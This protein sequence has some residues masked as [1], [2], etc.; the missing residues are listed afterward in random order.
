MARAARTGEEV[1][2]D[3]GPDGYLKGISSPQR[4]A[5]AKEFGIK[6]IH[7]VPVA[8]GVVEY[9]RAAGEEVEITRLL[10]ALMYQILHPQGV[11]D[12]VKKLGE[13]GQLLVMLVKLEEA[14]ALT[15]LSKAVVALY[16]AVMSYERSLERDVLAAFT[17][18]RSVEGSQS[19]KK[20]AAA[21][22]RA[23]FLVNLITPVFAVARGIILCSRF[24]R[25][26]WSM[27]NDAVIYADKGVEQLVET[28]RQVRPTNPC[29]CVCV[30]VCACV[31]VRVC[32]SRHR[33]AWDET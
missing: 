26:L 33:W 5:L 22:G 24:L 10:N 4:R 2:L 25:A 30:C 21:R 17:Y 3:C 16:D 23:R 28:G 8:G 19:L 13:V 31:C 9:G 20:D 15:G 1:V 11:R 27:R 7:F 29:V 18:A 32:T 6:H 12:C 14:S